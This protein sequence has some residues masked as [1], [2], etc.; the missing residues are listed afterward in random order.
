MATF[1]LTAFMWVAL[2]TLTFSAS[3]VA[4]WKPCSS[5]LAMRNPRGFR[6]PSTPLEAGRSGEVPGEEGS[7]HTKDDPGPEV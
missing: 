1:G 3:P 4:S 5:T 6:A 2:S 7:L